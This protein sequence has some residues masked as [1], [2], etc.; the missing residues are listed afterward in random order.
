M[1]STRARIL[2]IEDD[3]SFRQ[4]LS[5]LLLF[6]GYDV[7]SAG[8]G[9]EGLDSLRQ[10]EVMPDLIVADVIMG[11]MDGCEFLQQLRY[12]G[13]AWSQVACIMI[14]TSR[15]FSAACPESLVEPDA[16]L[17]KPFSNEQLLTLVETVWQSR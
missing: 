1:E 11:Q 15:T 7:T 6:A 2:I 10:A 5:E 17:T 14:S 16:Y 8:N 9:S 13:E 4:L 3:P 12:G